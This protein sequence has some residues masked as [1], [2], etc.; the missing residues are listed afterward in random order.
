MNI[1]PLNAE[2]VTVVAAWV[3]TIP[4]WQRYGA[5]TDVL[6][7]RLLMALDTDLILTADT[8]DQAVGL[9][10]C[11][12][13]GGFGR[14]AYL[15]MLG[16]RPDQAGAGVGAALLSALEATVASHDLFLLTSDFNVDAQRFYQ[17]QGYEQIGAIPG[18][19]L[20]DVTELIYRKRLR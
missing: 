9:A 15:R 5:S 13:K 1:R 3:V 18:Y 4:L 20:P 17:R 14:S 11:V 6:A 16:V 10:W 12:P 19:V 2:D 8:D 7:Q